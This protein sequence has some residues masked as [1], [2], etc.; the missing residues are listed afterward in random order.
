MMT[1]TS[2]PTPDE[3]AAIRARAEA[4]TSGPWY[5]HATDDEWSMNARYVSTTPGRMEHDGEWGMTTGTAPYSEV[6]AITLLQTPR[7]AC[8]ASER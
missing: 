1:D 2:P 6:V 3:L 4:A 7:L 8:H 5:A